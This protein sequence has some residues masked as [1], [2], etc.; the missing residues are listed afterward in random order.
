MANNE[1]SGAFLHYPFR[2]A[3]VMYMSGL[4]VGGDMQRMTRPKYDHNGNDGSI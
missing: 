2:V 1:F 4:P 3:E